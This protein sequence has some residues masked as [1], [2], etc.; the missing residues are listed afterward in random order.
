MAQIEALGSR[1]DDLISHRFPLDRI[2][3]AFEAQVE[4]RTAK[5]ILKPWGME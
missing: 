1:L 3:E 2:Q 5:V 4:G